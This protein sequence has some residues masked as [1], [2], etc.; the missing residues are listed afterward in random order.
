MK[1]TLIRLWLFTAALFLTVYGG[2]ARAQSFTQGDDPLL[3]TPEILVIVDTS[4][5]MTTQVTDIVTGNV[6]CENNSDGSTCYNCTSTNVCSK[7]TN[8]SGSCVSVSGFSNTGSTDP[9]T[10]RILCQASNTCSMCI[11]SSG[12]CVSMSGY[13]DSGRADLTTGREICQNPTQTCKKC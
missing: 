2:A 9:I 11:N 7:C 6:L 13:L 3:V 5:S 4:G 8:S 1:R 10:G 12:S